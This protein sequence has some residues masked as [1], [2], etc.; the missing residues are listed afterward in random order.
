MSKDKEPRTLSEAIERL[1][2][3]AKGKAQE[4]KQILGKDFQELNESLAELKPH[5]QSLK[6]GIER[7][8][9]DLQEK[10]EKGVREKPL[11]ALGLVGLFAFFIGWLFGSSRRNS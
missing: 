9:K 6:Q 11:I 4:L 1:E 5:L 2:N 8:S 10:V 3:T 7:E